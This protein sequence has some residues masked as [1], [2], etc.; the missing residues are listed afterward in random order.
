MTN[1]HHFESFQM[2]L[3]LTI[4]GFNCVAGELIF[5]VSPAVTALAS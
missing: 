3:T 5:C 4:D 2:R 1:D